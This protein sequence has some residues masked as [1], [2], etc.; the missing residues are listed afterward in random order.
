MEIKKIILDLLPSE[1]NKNNILLEVYNEDGSVTKSEEYL[2]DMLYLFLLNSYH[3][4]KS[5][6]NLILLLEDTIDDFAR[7][8]A[9]RADEAARM[10]DKLLELT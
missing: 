1:T 8:L 6:E 7:T 2:P 9:R 10:R 3:Q 5:Q 4:V